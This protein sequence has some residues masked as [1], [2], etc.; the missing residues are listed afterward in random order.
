MWDVTGQGDCWGYRKVTKA[1][2]KFMACLAQ[3]TCSVIRRSVKAFVVTVV[4][5][6]VVVVVVLVVGGGGE[7]KR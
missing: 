1:V 2:E 6:V 5:V 4:V 7:I 3:V